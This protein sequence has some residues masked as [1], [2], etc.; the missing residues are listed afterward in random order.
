MV[1]LT[2]VSGSTVVLSDGGNTTLHNLIFISDQIRLIQ[3][4]HSVIGSPDRSF[5]FHASIPPGSVQHKPEH[6]PDKPPNEEAIPG[7]D[8]DATDVRRAIETQPPEHHR[9]L[10]NSNSNM[11]KAS[12]ILRTVSLAPAPDCPG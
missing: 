9:S 8:P 10:L 4:D 12:N 7:Q 5:E 6:K 1:N 11:E 2:A 3:S